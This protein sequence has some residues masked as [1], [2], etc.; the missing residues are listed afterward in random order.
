LGL[1]LVRQ[2]V[3]R[4]HG[5]VDAFNGVD[6]LVVRMRFPEAADSPRKTE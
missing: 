1:A 6:G 2:V 5:M 3:V 4:A